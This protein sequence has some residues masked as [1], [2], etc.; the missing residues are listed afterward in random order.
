MK[1]ND[2][3]ISINLCEVWGESEYNTKSGH[4][5]PGQVDGWESI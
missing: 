4:N 3:W 2:R 1:R 5:N